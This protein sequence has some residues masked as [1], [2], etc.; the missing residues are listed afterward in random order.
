MKENGK[1]RWRWVKNGKSDEM[2]K[3][4]HTHMRYNL[5]Y[6]KG[7]SGERKGDEI[8][9]KQKMSDQANSNG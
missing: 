1:E 3:K 9:W 8:R 6:R 5:G 2:M 4:K 7:I